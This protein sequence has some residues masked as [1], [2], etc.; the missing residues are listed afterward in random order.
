M[1]EE[2]EVD[3]FAEFMAVMARCIPRRMPPDVRQ[4]WIEHQERLSTRLDSVLD[5][6][7]GEAWTV[8]PVQK[9]ASSLLFTQLLLACQQSWVNSD[10]SEAHFPLMYDGTEGPIEEFCFNRGMAG[11][12]VEAELR[13]LG[14]Q[15]VGMKRGMEHIA[16]HLGSQLDHPIAVV[17]AQWKSLDEDIFVPYFFAHGNSRDRRGLDF[18]R[19]SRKSLPPNCHFL[20]SRE[21]AAQ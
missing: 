20:V 7:G 18:R 10:V 11:M 13:K 8:G 1:A 19:L 16:S 21:P 17:G 15:I 6:S 9:P 14:F 4:Y 12:D 5:F 3:Q 2:T